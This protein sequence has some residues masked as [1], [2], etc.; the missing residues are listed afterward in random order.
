MVKEGFQRGNKDFQK[1][2]KHVRKGDE[3]YETSLQNPGETLFSLS[4]E[5][6][7]KDLR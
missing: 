6:L 7:S 2:Y 4:L 1:R 3:K 5:E